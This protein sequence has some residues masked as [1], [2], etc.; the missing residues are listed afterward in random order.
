MSSK[1]SL[2]NG[3]EPLALALI[4]APEP[5]STFVGIALLA[6]ARAAKASRQST[7]LTKQQRTRFEDYY[8]YRVQLLQDQQIVYGIKPKRDGLLPQIPPRTT[9]LYET[10]AWD[11][12]RRSAYK[13]L[14]DKKPTKPFSGL[15]RG[16]L[17]GNKKGLNKPY[18]PK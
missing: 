6:A 13:Y 14:N 2:A 18:F 5:V 9:K 11:Y 12:Y 3:L 7:Y 1:L 15:Q 8:H 16:L 17:E 10:E 4:F